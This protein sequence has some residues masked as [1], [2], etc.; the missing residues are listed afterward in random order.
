VNP[1]QRFVQIREAGSPPEQPV[2]V[3]L[4]GHLSPQRRRFAVGPQTPCC[5]TQ[6]RIDLGGLPRIGD[7]GESE[8]WRRGANAGKGVPSCWLPGRVRK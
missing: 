1:P 5:S 6:V 7:N 3:P 8:N 4:Q 2:E